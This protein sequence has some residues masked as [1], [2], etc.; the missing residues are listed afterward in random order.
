MGITV[1]DQSR[2]DLKKVVEGVKFVIQAL[3]AKS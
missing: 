2:G 1:V 3:S